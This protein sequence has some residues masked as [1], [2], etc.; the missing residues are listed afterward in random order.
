M[1]VLIVGTNVRNVAESARKAGYEVYTLTKYVDADLRIYAERVE[2]IGEDKERVEKRVKELAEELNAG[3]VLT[4]G[5]EDLKVDVEVL[6]CDPREAAKA[7]NKLKFY[8]TL[9]KAGIPFP[10]LLS[11]DEAKEGETI[12]KPR[13]G[14]GGENVK[15]FRNDATQK[16]IIFQRYIDGIPCSVSLIAGKEVY[17]ISINRILAGWRDMNADGFKYAGNFAPFIPDPEMRRELIKTAIETVELF[18]FSGSVGVDFILADEPY[19]LEVNPRFQGSLDCIEWSC[20]INLFRLHMLGVNGKKIDVQKPKRFAARTILFADRRIEIKV[21]PAGNPFFAD[22]PCRGD[23]YDKEWPLI[24]IL[25]SG[26]SREEIFD[27][28]LKRRDLFMKMQH[29][30]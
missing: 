10:E 12:V 28:I 4:T 23:V 2:R 9:E 29:S 3:V 5:F 21:S 11:Q 15:L 18:D 20:D 26:N 13:R 14:G 17:A 22:V 16:D 27:K 25:A 8:R 6:G 30:A 24:S 19:V 7:T 1:R